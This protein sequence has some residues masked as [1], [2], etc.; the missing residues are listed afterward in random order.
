MKMSHLIHY[1]VVCM[2]ELLEKALGGLRQ[3]MQGCSRNNPAEVERYREQQLLLEGE[4]SKVR[5]LLAHKSKVRMRK[6]YFLF[7]QNATEFLNL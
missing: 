3:K 6:R 5:V 2:Q 4:L 1:I 7:V